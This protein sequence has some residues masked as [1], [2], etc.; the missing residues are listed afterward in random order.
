MISNPSNSSD[1]YLE[2]CPT[3][4]RLVAFDRGDLSESMILPISEHLDSCNRCQDSMES[5]QPGI[6][7]TSIQ[8]LSGC[9]QTSQVLNSDE[10]ADSINRV[11]ER[12]N[13]ANGNENT[14]FTAPD[15]YELVEYLGSGQFGKVWKSIYKPT[16]D[17]FAL[18]ITCNDVT[19]D[20]SQV[21]CFLEDVKKA[22]TLSHPNLV[23]VYDYGRWSVSEA[24]VAMERIHGKKLSRWLYKQDGRPI[25]ASIAYFKQILDAVEFLH[26]HDVLH[27][28]L[29]PENVFINRLNR[30]VIT[31]V[32]MFVDERYLKNSR[33]AYD[34]EFFYFSSPEQLRFDSQQI[35]KCSDIFSLGRILMKIIDFA[36]GYRNE[37]N[38]KGTVLAPLVEIADSCTQ[39]LVA[40]RPKSIGQIRAALQ[41]ADL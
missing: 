34:P 31:D 23:K 30:V 3:H 5:L 27:R 28:N 39:P 37:S 4:E 22:Q 40:Q 33:P 36:A 8:E 6:F 24:Y 1:S 12:L 14:E 11:I 2:V 18:K 38:L 35:G 29:K 7:E 21:E 32:G 10:H 25:R 17:K 13:G 26:E 16:G 9:V 15:K 41:E 19:F 20:R